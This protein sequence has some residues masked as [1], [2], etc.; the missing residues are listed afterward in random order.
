ML[1]RLVG[2]AAA[3]LTPGQ[4]L[5]AAVTCPDGPDWTRERQQRPPIVEPAPVV[6]SRVELA[7]VTTPLVPVRPGR[8]TLNPALS[9]ALI[10]TYADGAESRVIVGGASR[11]VLRR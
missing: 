4:V 6:A 1:G 2:A 3:A 10:C 7:E 8:W 9:Y 5:A 11:L